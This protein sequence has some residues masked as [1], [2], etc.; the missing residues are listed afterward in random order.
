MFDK[1]QILNLKQICMMPFLTEMFT[2][3]DKPV[4]S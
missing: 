1:K 4:I 3:I 2:L